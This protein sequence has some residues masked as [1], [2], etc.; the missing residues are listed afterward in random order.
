MELARRVGTDIKIAL[1]RTLKSQFVESR[2]LLIQAVLVSL[3]TST[4]SDTNGIA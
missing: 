1:A 2:L 4:L 3:I